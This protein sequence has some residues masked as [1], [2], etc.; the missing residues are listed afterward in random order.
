MIVWTMRAQRFEVYQ[1]WMLWCPHYFLTTA[2]RDAARKQE[3]AA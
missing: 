3:V 2:Q 1:R